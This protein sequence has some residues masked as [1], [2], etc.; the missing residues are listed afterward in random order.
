M[1][2]Q[3]N[4]TSRDLELLNI[5]LDHALTPQEQAEFNKRLSECSYLTTLYQQQRRLKSTMGQLPCSK[6]PHNFTLTRDEARKAKRGGF[7]QPMFG[8][9][10]LVS[11][12]LVAVIFG[13]ELIFRTFS[14]TAPNPADNYET[15]LMQEEAPMA[16]MPEESAGFKTL[17]SEQVYLLNWSYGATGL[18]GIGGM[19]GGGDVAESGGVSVNIY[20]N[21]ETY[22]SEDLAVEGVGAGEIV[23]DVP[24]DAIIDAYPE[25]AVPEQAVPEA[26]IAE[27][28]VAEQETIPEEM[29]MAI[30]APM[31]REAPRIYGIDSEK[32]GT[33]LKMTPDSS[34]IQPEQVSEHQLRTEEES[35]SER[36]IPI[37]VSIA[38]LSA[39]LVFGLVWLFLKFKQ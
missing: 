24:M 22:Y 36:F 29:V 21:P 12:L 23:E 3:E 25:E 37:Q 6:V 26:E 27:Q 19:G 34:V 7:L 9:A 14:L 8:W 33:I 17:G 35:S 28:E 15:S 38:L 20:I 32:V 11:A 16:A 1:I 10:S 5:A 30:P 39:A 31:E 13:S 18:G 4:V 2:R